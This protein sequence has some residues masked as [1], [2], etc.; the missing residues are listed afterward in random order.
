MSKNFQIVSS[1]HRSTYGNRQ[2]LGEDDEDDEEATLAFEME[3]QQ[4]LMH[5]QDNTLD[6][7]G[8]AITSLRRQAGTLGQEIG[9]QVEMIGALDSEVDHSQS[10]LNRA[11]GKMDELVRRSDDRMGGWCVWLLIILLMVLALIAFII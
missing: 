5:K 3:Q 7:I 2:D 4:Q 9:E 10:K 6:L 1:G 8:N 11:L